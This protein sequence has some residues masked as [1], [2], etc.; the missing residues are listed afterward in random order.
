[1][2]AWISL[3]P[4]DQGLGSGLE[5]REMWITRATQ[6]V[7]MRVI[8]DLIDLLRLPGCNLRS[9]VIVE[10]LNM[11]PNDSGHQRGSGRTDPGVS[12]FT[13]SN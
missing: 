2:S 8:P 5:R 10:N 7:V 9:F 12:L 3:F 4:N 1:M 6:K 13:K 11:P